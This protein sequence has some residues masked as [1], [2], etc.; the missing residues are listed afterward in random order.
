MLE[1]III[2]LLLITIILIVFSLY[3]IHQRGLQINNL[4]QTEALSFEQTQAAIKVLSNEDVTNAL[5]ASL[6]KQQIS[7]KIG[8]FTTLSANMEE[9]TRKFN[10]MVAT[11][12]KRAGW[13][14]WHLEQELKEAFPSVKIRKEVKELGNLKPDAHM[15]TPDGKILI[16]DSKFVYDTYN[17]ILETPETQVATKEKLQKIFRG[18]IE[19]H[20]YK[21]KDDY[22]QPG[23][24]THEFAFMFIP[25]T[26][27]Y[28]FLIENE[29]K[30]VRWAASQGV[31]ICSPMT[32]MANMHMLEIAR[33]A[34]NM[35]NMH[36]EILDAHLRVQKCYKDFE[37][38]YKTLSDHLNK[39][40]KKNNEVSG[41]V[42][43][44]NSEISALTS[45]D[46]S[47]EEGSDD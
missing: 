43:E 5:N 47:I 3:L 2:G 7:E 25:S 4:P 36:N 35:T 14:E 15:R 32:L 22:V 28:E 31:V 1:Q 9:A 42:N 11:K 20:V 26:A 34:Q 12:S 29:S 45:L 23:K 44:M 41:K 30:T 27:V 19:K 13:G 46:K 38:Q 33:M 17:S 8:N 39:A 16:V 24:G 37:E 18:D 21:I 40:V 10:Q 6:T